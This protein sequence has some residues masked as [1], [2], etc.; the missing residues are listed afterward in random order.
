MVVQCVEFCAG[1]SWEPTGWWE[2]GMFREGF[3]GEV[4][5]KLSQSLERNQRGPQGG[6][7]LLAEKHVQRPGCGG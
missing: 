5:P 6:D 4:T 3:L 7:V 1:V 2:T